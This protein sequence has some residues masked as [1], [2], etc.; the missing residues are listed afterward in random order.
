MAA[1]A[2]VAVAVAVAATAAA[3]PARSRADL[4]V[5][6]GPVRHRA[7][8]VFQGCRVKNGNSNVRVR[9]AVMMCACALL[10]ACKQASA[11]A[12]PPAASPEVVRYAAWLAPKMASSGMMSSGGSV[13]PI[14]DDSV[15][16]RT[17]G[18]TVVMAF[19]ADDMG[20]TPD[21]A[22]AA[23][24]QQAM[25][26]RICQMSEVHDFVAKGGVFRM[27]IDVKD[28]RVVPVSTV[29]HCA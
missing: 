19:M 14:H 4:Y 22:Q 27:E 12:S 10:P 17:E 16:F 25:A 2:V 1:T 6:L 21:S 29:D 13:T 24:A 26:G 5:L 8:G 18:G 9:A 11:S 20:P 3:S 23:Q 28:G 15:R 7:C